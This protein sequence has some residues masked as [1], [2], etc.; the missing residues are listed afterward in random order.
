MVG[1]RG[2]AVAS[3][4]PAAELASPEEAVAAYLS[5]V[6]AADLAAIE[7]TI[8]ASDVAEHLDFVALVDRLGS[9]SPAMMGPSVGPLFTDINRLHQTSQVIGQ[10][11]FLLYSLLTDI[12]F[13]G[14]TLV[15]DAEWAAEF[16]AAL[17][18]SRLAALEV[19][20]V[21]FPKA[22]LADDAR[23]ADSFAAVAAV[24]GADELTE[25][26]ALV[27]FEGASYAVGFTLL[28]YGS[29]WRVS[30]QASALAGLPSLGVAVPTTPE[31]F[32]ALT[33]ATSDATEP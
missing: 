11:R 24:W 15:V 10:T 25:R 18:A 23:T 12:E 33:G 6:A 20:D 2:V 3:S 26:V 8:A 30:S 29:Q 4:A 22:E 32:D 1:R 7:S 31:D 5:G 27:S 19:V 28:R 16:I 14:V 17:D 9:W 21:R 13:E